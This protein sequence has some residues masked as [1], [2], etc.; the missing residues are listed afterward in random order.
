MLLKGDYDEE[1]GPIREDREKVSVALSERASAR[2]RGARE[3]RGGGREDLA[4]VLATGDAR[5]GVHQE[6]E[7]RPGEARDLRKGAAER[8][9]GETGGVRVG[10]VVGWPFGQ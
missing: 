9:H 6:C 1:C 10:N 2:A 5:D 3:G 4:E 8:L 7:E